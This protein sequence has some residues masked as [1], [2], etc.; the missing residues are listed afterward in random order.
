MSPVRCAAQ[1]VHYVA[2]RKSTVAQSCHKNDVGHQ[3]SDICWCYEPLL[4]T[5]VQQ[6]NES[7]GIE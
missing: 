4:E 6:F 5:L 2:V 1:S 3:C 7:L